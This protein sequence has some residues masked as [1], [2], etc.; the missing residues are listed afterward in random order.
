[1]S[2]YL[3]PE[4]FEEMKRVA[5]QATPLSETSRSVRL[6]ESI[7]GTAFGDVSYVLTISDDGMSI[8]TASDQD[9][10]VTFTQDYETAAELHRGELTTQ[11]AF[12]A[13]RVRVSGN[14]NVL[15]DHADLLQGVAPL[16][17]QVRANTTY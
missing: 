15:L 10:D 8:N 5:A 11:E 6:R 16:F 4:W 3:S 1:M 2:Q 14:L 13:G 7:T 12:F 9:A 17:E